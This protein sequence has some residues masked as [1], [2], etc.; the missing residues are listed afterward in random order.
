MQEGRRQGVERGTRECGVVMH[1]SFIL[2]A[3][4]VSWVYTCVEIYQIVHLNTCT[5]S[6][7]IYT[8]RKQF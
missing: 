4:V 1:M 2:I 7:V 3:A 8:L 5:L 6:H